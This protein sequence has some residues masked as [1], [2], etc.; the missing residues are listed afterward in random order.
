MKRP[1]PSQ[2]AAI[3]VAVLLLIVIRTLGEVFRLEYVRGDAL[4]L[5]EIRPFIVGAL[6]A[7][8]ALAVSLLANWA[9]RLRLSAIIAAS[10]VVLLIIYKVTAIGW[11]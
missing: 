5:G 7:S 4:T 6:A 3:G 8:V 9:G 2:L 10:T 11:L 1:S